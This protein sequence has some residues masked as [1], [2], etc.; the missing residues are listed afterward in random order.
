MKRSNKK[1]KT[2]KCYVLSVEHG[3]VQI[4]HTVFQPC[5]NET[6]YSGNMKGCTKEN[7]VEVEGSKDRETA[8]KALKEYYKLYR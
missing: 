7:M 2:V 6:I 1:V 4:G 8:V 5:N 3:T